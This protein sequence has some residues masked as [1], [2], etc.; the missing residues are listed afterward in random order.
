MIVAAVRIKKSYKLSWKL[1]TVAL[2]VKSYKLIQKPHNKEVLSFSKFN[3]GTR[4]YAQTLDFC[5]LQSFDFFLP[6]GFTDAV[7]GMAYLT[8]LFLL[9]LFLENFFEFHEKSGRE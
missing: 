6:R 7:L 9:F 4:I 3:Q 5:Q 1:D 8:L 2:R